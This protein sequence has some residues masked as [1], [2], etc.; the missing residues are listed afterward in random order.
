M[1]PSVGVGIAW[2]WTAAPNVIYD[3]RVN[4]A[5]A[6]LGLPVAAPAQS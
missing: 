5:A 6:T 3:D 2:R 4:D 1:V